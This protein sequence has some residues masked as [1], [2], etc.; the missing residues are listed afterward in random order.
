M[1]VTRSFSKGYGLAGIRLGYLI[2]RPEMVEQLTKIKD[3]YN[4][5]TLSQVAGVAAISDQDY[6]RE[7][8][9]RIIAT[10]NGL[11]HELRAMGYTVPDSQS[12]FVWATRGPRARE[13]FQKLKDRK[14]LVRLMTYRVIPTGSRMTIGT[15]SEIDRSS[16]PCKQLN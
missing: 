14:I 4:C 12:N 10:R 7:T 11:T 16:R 5:D 8:R 9:S 2:A 6:L 1:I 15:D 3:S 13:T